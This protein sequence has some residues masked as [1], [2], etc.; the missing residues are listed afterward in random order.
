MT[1]TWKWNCVTCNCMN[2]G[3]CKVQFT[4]WFPLLQFPKSIIVQ[5]TSNTRQRLPHERILFL[6]V[7][8]SLGQICTHQRTSGSKKGTARPTNA[9]PQSNTD[10]QPYHRGMLGSTKRGGEFQQHHLQCHWVVEHG[11]G[12]GKENEHRKLEAKWP[13]TT[14]GP[15]IA[16]MFWPLCW[17]L[18]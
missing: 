15:F 4:Q 12:G 17:A 1:D 14:N 13:R 6:G 10:Q 7:V 9:N 18:F 3:N 8:Q 16:A 2:T 11:D 5:L